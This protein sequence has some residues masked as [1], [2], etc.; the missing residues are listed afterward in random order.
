[1]MNL[2]EK[3]REDCMPFPSLEA[4]GEEPP[5]CFY[6]ASLLFRRMALNHVDQ[7]EIAENDPLLFYELQGLCTLCRSKEQCVRDLVNE[8][9]DGSSDGWREYCPN[10][11]AFAALEIQ[12]N[13]GLAAQHGAGY[14]R[15]VVTK[16]G[17]VILRTAK[18]K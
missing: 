11:T 1:M 16:L 10:A 18:S 4:V 5:R 6:D 13:C 2:L 12:Q 8:A 3:L 9:S 17:S 7:A 14:E 15:I